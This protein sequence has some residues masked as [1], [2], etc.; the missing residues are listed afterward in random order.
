MSAWLR[1]CA[2]AL[3]LALSG[4]AAIEPGGGCIPG[5]SSLTCCLKENPGQYERCAVLAGEK[6]TTLRPP[7]VLAETP[8]EGTEEDA[9]PEAETPAEQKERFRKICLPYYERCIAKGGEHKPGRVWKETQ[10]RACYDSCM[11]RGYWP[12]SANGKRCPGA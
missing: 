3:L 4:C 5:D 12:H 1:C 7:P 6:P 8:Q 11:R 10:C 2:G 9:A